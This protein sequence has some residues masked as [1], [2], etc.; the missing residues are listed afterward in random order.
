MVVAADHPLIGKIPACERGDDVVN[1]LQAPVRF[2]QQMYFRS[3]RS[4]VIGDRQGAAPGRR[5]HRT[6]QS[7]ENGL[8]IGPRYR[9]HRNLHQG[10]RIFDGQARRTCSR[11]HARRQR[12]A[13]IQRHISDRAALYAARGAPPA[14]RI[15][16][17]GCIAIFMRVRVDQA[18]HGAMFMGQLGLQSA[19]TAAIACQYDLAGH[20]DT[21]TRQFQVIRV[22]AEIHIDDIGRDVAIGAVDVVRRQCTGGRT[23]RIA[24]NRRLDQLRDMLRWRQHFHPFGQRRGIQH[25]EGFN[26]GVPAPRGQHVAHF[27]RIPAIVRRAHIVGRSGQVLQPR[28]Q[29]GRVDAGIELVLQGQLSAAARS[30][31]A[32]QVVGGGSR[33]GNGRQAA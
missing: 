32:D 20:T 13:R 4:Q 24:G 10:G 11:S 3:A 19:P 25:R 28:P 26:A 29:I 14:G 30:I 31:E 22:H 21:P 1:R 2:H 9:Q 16:I 6:G 23:A 8:R 15:R 12:I 18:A 33:A 27:F 5:R 7:G 17:A